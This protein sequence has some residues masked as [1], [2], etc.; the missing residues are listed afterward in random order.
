MSKKIY[1]SPEDPELEQ[2][3]KCG[4]VLNMFCDILTPPLPLEDICDK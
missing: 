2:A 1:H 3:L 4:G